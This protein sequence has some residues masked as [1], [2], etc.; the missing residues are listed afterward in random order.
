[1][2]KNKQ[3]EEMCAIMADASYAACEDT[4]LVPES[5]GICD[6]VDCH[7]CKEA[8]RLMSAGYRK[9]SEVAREIFEEIEAHFDR[10]IAFYQDMRF[11]AYS[12]GKD[13]EVKYANTMITNLTIYKEEIAELKKKYTESEDT[14]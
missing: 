8:R 11:R 2:D 6:K 7:R 5:A 3:I 9:D 13:E 1:M 12:V 14:E 10:K 4:P